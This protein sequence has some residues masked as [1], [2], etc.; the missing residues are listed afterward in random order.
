MTILN[1]FV[2]ML[3]SP[4]RVFDDI[5]EGRAGWVQ[6]WIIISVLYMIVTAVGMPIQIALVEL[7]TRGVAPEMIDQQVRMMQM[8][9]GL[10]WVALT[11][12]GVLLIQLIVAGVTYVLVTTLSQRAT[13]RQYLALN[14]FTGIPA[15]L[16]QLLSVSILRLRG[17]DRIMGPD[18]ARMSFSLRMLAPPDNAVLKGVFSGIEFFTIWSLVLLGMGLQR[19]FGMSRGQA[20]AV[21]VLLWLIYV[22]LLVLGE[23][24]GGIGA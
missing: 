3:T 18:D 15:M 11:P 13:F 14:F 23:V 7:N 22:V 5:R 1:R 24:M 19:V 17:L 8:P 16:G 2:C 9:L 10:I 4:G 20:V 12:V 21:L 6:P